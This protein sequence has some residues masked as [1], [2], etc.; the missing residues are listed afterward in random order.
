[1]DGFD[2][3]ISSLKGTESIVP[4]LPEPVIPP[5]EPHEYPLN[6]R[7]VLLVVPTSNQSKRDLLLSAFRSRAPVGLE[8]HVLTLPVSSEVG[9]QPYNKAGIIGAYNRINNALRALDS[10][11][12]HELLRRNR[13]GTIMVA[14]IEN[15]IEIERAERP[16][17]FGV[18]VVHNATTRETRACVSKGTT[19]D[20]RFVE[21][22]LSLGYG[23][24][25]YYG[26][27]TVGK[28]LAG[29]FPGIDESNWHAVLVGHSRYDILKEAVDGLELPWDIKQEALT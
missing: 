26:K 25:P 29:R 14:S 5:F 28:I 19:V 20:P 18:V 15:Y 1:M 27:V 21:S 3:L 22:A 4:P 10:D 9:E 11:E 7:A 8:L 12:H 24:H 13:I 17:D 23:E 16:T 6:G 2:S